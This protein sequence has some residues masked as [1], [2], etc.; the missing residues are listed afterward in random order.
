MM[1]QN[2]IF[3]FDGTLADT[4]EGILETEKA[5]LR[6]L[7]LPIPPDEQMRAGIGLPLALSLEKGCNL[8]HDIVPEAVRIY[9]EFFFDVAPRHI[10]IFDGVRET[11]DQLRHRG[12]DMAI[13]TSRGSGSLAKILEVHGLTDYFG[14]TLTADSGIPL[15]PRPD[16]VFEL[17]RLMSQANGASPSAADID[18]SETAA[19]TLVVGDTTFDIDMG[20]SALCRTVAVSYGNHPREVL[21]TSHPTWII[22]RFP[23]ILEL[24]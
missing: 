18:L 21:Q 24:I 8:P 5:M 20:N 11:L 1:V 4:A 22:D 19:H 16:M 12:I 2:I 7:A 9:R 23:Q 17:V 15:K 3:D 14:H 6:K 13:A 10:I